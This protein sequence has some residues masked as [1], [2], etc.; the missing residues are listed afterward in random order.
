MIR[1]LYILKWVK[2]DYSVYATDFS[3]VIFIQID[4]DEYEEEEEQDEGDDEGEQ[5]YT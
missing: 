4:M 1:T 2:E 3:L 5:I